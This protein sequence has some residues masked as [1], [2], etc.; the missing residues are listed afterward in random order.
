LFLKIKNFLEMEK[1]YRSRKT[2]LPITLE[3]EMLEAKELIEEWNKAKEAKKDTDPLY[4]IHWLTP[5]GAT[6]HGQ[7]CTLAM[8][9]VITGKPDLLADSRWNSVCVEHWLV[10]Q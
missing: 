9:R 7:P 5:T 6:G 1:G 10:P 4:V 3:E 8:I 2:G